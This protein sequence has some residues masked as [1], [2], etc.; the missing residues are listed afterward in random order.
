MPQLN[1]RALG[2][3]GIT[4]AVAAVGYF[5]AQFAAVERSYAGLRR[6]DA[7]ALGAL[8]DAADDYVLTSREILRR[9]AVANR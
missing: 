6:L 8:G 3:F 5:E 9:I 2:V 7:A 4:L 1:P